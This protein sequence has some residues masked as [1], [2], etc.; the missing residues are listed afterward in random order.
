MRFSRQRGERSCYLG[1][2]RAD[3]GGHGPS[4]AAVVFMSG[5]GL[6]DGEAEVALDP[7]QDR[8]PYP[9]C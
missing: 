9:V 6:G 5:V 7:G 1:D 8:V 2:A 3:V 4:T